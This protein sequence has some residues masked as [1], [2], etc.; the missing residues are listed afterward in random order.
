[1]TAVAAVQ[2]AS[3]RLLLLAYAGYGRSFRRAA[4]MIMK[5]IMM[6]GFMPVAGNGVFALGIS[7]MVTMATLVLHIFFGALLGYSYSKLA[8]QEK[9]TAAI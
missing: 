2:F 4:I 6:I 5:A 8:M 7:P 3:A 1:M 9:L